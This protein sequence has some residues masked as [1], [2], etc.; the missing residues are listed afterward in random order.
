M[1]LAPAI[2]KRIPA[3]QEKGCGLDGQLGE[4]GSGMMIEERVTPDL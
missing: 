1:R 3:C 2:R 4:R